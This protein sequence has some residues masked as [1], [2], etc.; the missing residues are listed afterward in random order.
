[1]SEWRDIVSTSLGNP[2]F[3][4]T[5][6]EGH[7]N[8]CYIVDS[9]IFIKRNCLLFQRKFLSNAYTW[10]YLSFVVTGGNYFFTNCLILCDYEEISDLK[11]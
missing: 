11:T 10:R 9:S 4:T 1:M 2:N 7:M 8:H 3:F 5:I 6:P